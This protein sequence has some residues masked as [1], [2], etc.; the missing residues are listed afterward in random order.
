MIRHSTR[1]HCLQLTHLML[2]KLAEDH[3]DMIC[4]L[5]DA[6]AIFLLTLHASNSL[7]H[8]QHHFTSLS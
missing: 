2:P 6:F 1:E 7:S 4:T 8:Q 5:D 3:S